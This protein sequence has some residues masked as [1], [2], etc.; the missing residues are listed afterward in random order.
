VGQSRYGEEQ[1]LCGI[2]QRLSNRVSYLRRTARLG[3]PHEVMLCEEFQACGIAHVSGEENDA[4]VHG[5]RCG[6]QQVVQVWS[7]EF[8]QAQIA[9]DEVIVTRVNL[10]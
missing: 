9:Q 4:L 8:W 3:K 5:G 6:L 7:I 2:P 1:P 10:L